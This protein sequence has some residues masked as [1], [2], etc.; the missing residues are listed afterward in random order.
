MRPPVQA[1]RIAQRRLEKAGHRPGTI[2]GALDER[3]ERALDRVLGERAGDLDPSQVSAILSGS[4]NRKLAAYIQLLAVDEGL[5]TGP[6]DGFWGPQTQ[7]AFDNLAALEERG[8]IPRPFRD[9]EPNAANPNNWP[10]ESPESELRSF[11]GEPGDPGNLIS[12]EVPYVHRLSWDPGT[13]VNRITCHKK[14]AG[15]FVRVLEQ[16]IDHYGHDG[17]RALRLDLWGGCFNKRLK[18][19]GTTWSTHAWGIA[20]DYDPDRNRLNWGRARATFARPEY[21]VWWELWE[22]EG[23]TS[24]G[25]TAGFDWMHVQAARR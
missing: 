20:S 19:G 18:R 13:R 6:I 25:R 7:F 22:A 11:Y 4:R 24:L 14:V 5:E 10:L 8:E 12:V 16:V 21:D 2:E 15:S 1:V 3:T 17:V 9:L 23:W